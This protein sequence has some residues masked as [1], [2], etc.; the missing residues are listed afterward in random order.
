MSL[1][2]LKTPKT[3]FV[4]TWLKLYK[5]NTVIVR[6]YVFSGVSTFLGMIFGATRSL[7]LFV[8]LAENLK[9]MFSL[10]VGNGMVVLRL[11]GNTFD[12]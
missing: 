2:W 9:G 10:I 6:F 3:G 5:I 7:Y 8:L 4:I 1:T 11:L 12:I